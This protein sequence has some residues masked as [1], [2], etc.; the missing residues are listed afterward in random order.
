MFPEMMGLCDLLANFK[1]VANGFVSDV[2]VRVCIVGGVI[3]IIG[4]DKLE[5]TSGS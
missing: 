3:A 5:G 1:R 4:D 2:G